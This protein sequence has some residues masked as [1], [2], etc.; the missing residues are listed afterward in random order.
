MAKNEAFINQYNRLR[1]EY[2]SKALT[3]IRQIKKLKHEKEEADSF[4]RRHTRRKPMKHIISSCER[5]PNVARVEFSVKSRM[6]KIYRAE[7]YQ[8]NLQSYPLY[9]QIYYNDVVIRDE[10]SDRLVHI[11][12]IFVELPIDVSDQNST[13]QLYLERLDSDGNLIERKRNQ[14][15]R[16]YIHPHG[17]DMTVCCQ[18]DGMSYALHRLVRQYDFESITAYIRQYL[19]SSQHPEVLYSMILES[20]NID[21]DDETYGWDY[22]ED[23]SPNEIN[24]LRIIEEDFGKTVGI[25]TEEQYEAI[26]KREAS[27]KDKI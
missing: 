8:G 6:N 2:K 23:L 20:Q 4:L 24:S 21:E 10:D 5:I 3:A 26:I 12:H 18:A 15:V 9:I 27:K 22:I 14:Y 16:R 17:N 19:H 7:G 11:G 25:I 13:S 1:Q